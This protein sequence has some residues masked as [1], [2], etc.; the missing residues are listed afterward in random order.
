MY[1][2][3][4]LIKDQTVVV[5]LILFEIADGEQLMNLITMHSQKGQPFRRHTRNAEQRRKVVNIYRKTRSGRAMLQTMVEPYMIAHVVSTRGVAARCRG[6]RH[7]LLTVYR[8]CLPF[9]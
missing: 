6:L 9:A 4:G 2:I 3:V 7:G 8:C 1:D 5:E